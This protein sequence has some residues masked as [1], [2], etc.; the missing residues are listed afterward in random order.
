MRTQLCFLLFGLLFFSCKEVQ[1]GAYICPPCNRDCDHLY[2]QE[3]GICPHCKMKLI[4]ASE[5]IDESSLVLN[6]ITL[7]EGS[8]VFLIEGGKGRE[9][10]SIKVYYHQ[11]QSF[12]K[13]SKILMVIPGAGRNGDS[14]RDAWKEVSE[15]HK[16]LILAPKY[17]EDSYP[18]ED[19]HLCGLI[20]EVNLREV[21]RFQEGSNQAHLNEDS[22]K[23]S[24]NANR[25]SWLFS[26][27]DRIFDLVV[28]ATKSSQTKY[29]LF[30][31]SAGGQILHRL[32]LLGHG[33]KVNR[34]IAANSGFYTLPDLETH[35]PFGLKKVY[36]SE[37]EFAQSFE[38][39][40][41]LLIGELDNENERGGTLLKSKTVDKQGAHRLSRAR[42]FYDFSRKKAEALE[43]TYNWEI[44]IVAGVGHDH[45][46][47][48]KAAARILYE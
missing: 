13:D 22:L 1:K 4:K 11:P 20:K 24:I 47:M 12:S 32:A 10:K 35:L 6:E 28:K 48:G 40:L 18:F 44:E 38:T 31:H 9:E 16:V 30:G 46:L 29:D 23:F 7:K 3:A 14:Y 19:Y 26:D 36:S 21:I 39:Q 25:A 17:E 2:F 27:F 8:G 43:L 41:L 15:K 5:L 45:R 42:Y 33:A 34:I 37:K